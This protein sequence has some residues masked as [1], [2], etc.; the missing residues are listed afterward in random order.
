MT[1]YCKSAA[2]KTSLFPDLPVHRFRLHGLRK[3]SW[4]ER[5]GVGY[6]EHLEE[7]GL[8][9]WIEP[10]ALAIV[11]GPN[12]GGKGT[13]ID[14][15]RAVADAS[16]WPS[17]A[18]ENYP[19][20]DFS[21]FDIEGSGYLLSCRF[22]K[23]TPSADEMFESLTL[24]AAAGHGDNREHLECLAP[25]HPDSHEWASGVQDLLDRWVRV[26]CHYLSATGPHPA[27]DIDDATLVF[28]LNELSPH[29]PSVMANPATNP[30]SLFRG[31]ADR[32]G[33]I[34]V[35]FKDDP[36]QHSFVSRSVLPL[37]WLQLASVLH[38]VRG[39]RAQSLVLLDEPDRHLHPSLQRVLLELIAKEQRRVGMQL[40]SRLILP[41]SLTRNCAPALTHL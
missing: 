31:G 3:L 29:F 6:L 38:F 4:A 9:R 7:Q 14:L 36:G 39:C 13:I 26:H 8:G 34:G 5:N 40:S 16:I 11:V 20:D 28:L 2:E 12:G 24:V 17:L 35:L 33:R 15:L 18:R 1:Q 30:F 22:L 41:C 23:H 27:S 32:P 21:G 25:K 10:G 37:G 19:G